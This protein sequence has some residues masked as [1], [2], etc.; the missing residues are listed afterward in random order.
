MMVR[1]IY[2]KE[3]MLLLQRDSAVPADGMWD[4]LIATI[5]KRI[6]TLALALTTLVMTSNY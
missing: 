3:M 6:S 4:F 2:L 1:R 5:P